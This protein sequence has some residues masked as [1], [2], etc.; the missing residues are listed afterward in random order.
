MTAALVA[1]LPWTVEQLAVLRRDADLG[2]A[3]IATAT[4][5]TPESVRQKASKEGIPLGG[6]RKGPPPGA[7]A[8]DWLGDAACAG[9]DPDLWFPETGDSSAPAKSV[10]AHCPV[11]AECWALLHTL[12]EPQRRY[13]VWAG[14][15]VHDRRRRAEQ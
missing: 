13:G 5:R 10:C 1:Y 2:A 15:S 3:H 12:P 8:S 14:T 7:A 11:T 4:G 6:G 9:V